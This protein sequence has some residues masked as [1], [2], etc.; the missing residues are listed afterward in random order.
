MVA[1]R[2]SPLRVLTPCCCVLA[3]SVT[4][5]GKTKGLGKFELQSRFTVA[6]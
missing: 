5:A 6:L 1:A 4:P 3:A 2:L